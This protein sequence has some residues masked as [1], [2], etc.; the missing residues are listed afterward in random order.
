MDQHGTDIFH[1][2]IQTSVGLIF[3]HAPS[4]NINIKYPT[5][6]I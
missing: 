4:I 1:M 5:K 6:F 3:K 2:H